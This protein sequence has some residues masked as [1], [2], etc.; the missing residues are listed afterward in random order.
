MQ[1]HVKYIEMIKAYFYSVSTFVLYFLMYIHK[2]ISAQAIQIN[3]SGGSTLDAVEVNCPTPVTA[4]P[5]VDN[6]PSQVHYAYT[7]F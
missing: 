3:N 4:V 5:I 2:L 1:I 6:G 7:L